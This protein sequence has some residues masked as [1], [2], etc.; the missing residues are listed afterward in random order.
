MLIST[1]K[2][3]SRAY[4]LDTQSGGWQTQYSQVLIQGPSK[5]ILYILL[6]TTFTLEQKQ[7][8]IYST[9]LLFYVD[10]QTF[11]FVLKRD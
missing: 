4:T 11:T 9:K 8:L 1:P 2:Y 5:Y 7:T 3:Q 6:A 10:F